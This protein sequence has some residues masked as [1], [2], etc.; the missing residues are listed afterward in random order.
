[1]LGKQ[2][3]YYLKN[4]LILCLSLSLI[5]F[6]QRVK[7]IKNPEGTPITKM[8]FIGLFLLG[9]F[10][11]IGIVIQRIMQRS[12][13]KFVRDFPILGWVSITS[14]IFCMLSPFVVEAVNA[15]DFLSITTPILTYAGLSVANRLG[16]LKDV[17]YKVAITGIF[18]FLGTYLGS[19][20]LAQIG[21]LLTGK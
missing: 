6:T 2:M 15:V 3:N 18:V 12:P 8:T 9:M 4:A 10:A 19:A 13:I 16:D 7:L 14:L 11:L 17:S 5:L 20:L 21:L 1:M